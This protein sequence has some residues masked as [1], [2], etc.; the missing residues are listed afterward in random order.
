METLALI[1]SVAFIAGIVYSFV[2]YIVTEVI[3]EK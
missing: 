1:F 3:T 2:S